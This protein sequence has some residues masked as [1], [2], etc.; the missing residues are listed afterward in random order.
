MALDEARHGV[1]QNV[2]KG[3]R[4]VNERE[5]EA[6]EQEPSSYRWRDRLVTTDS[7]DFSRIRGHSFVWNA[8]DCSLFCMSTVATIALIVVSFPIARPRNTA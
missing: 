2:V 1:R 7:S 6:Q 5:N 4:G 8:D 3:G